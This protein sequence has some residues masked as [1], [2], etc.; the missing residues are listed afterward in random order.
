MS[1]VNEIVKAKEFE[2]LVLAA[3][4][5][6]IQEKKPL[7]GEAFIKTLFVTAEECGLIKF[8]DTENCKGKLALRLG[9]MELPK[10]DSAARQVTEKAL[11]IKK[12]DKKATVESW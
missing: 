2:S 12:E 4:K 7:N 1:N 9:V 8:V 11:G 6:I 5:D 10:N 3:F